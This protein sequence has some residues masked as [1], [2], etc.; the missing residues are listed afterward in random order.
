MMGPLLP[1][2]FFFVVVVEVEVQINF[3][4]QN[5]SLSVWSGNER[6]PCG[7]RVTWPPVRHMHVRA[8]RQ[9]VRVASA[10]LLLR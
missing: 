7:N 4:Y 1:S 9:D 5:P 2:L 6:R 10:S 3:M 8:R